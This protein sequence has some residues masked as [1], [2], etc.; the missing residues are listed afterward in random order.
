MLLSRASRAILLISSL[1]YFR[2]RVEKYTS[3]ISSNLVLKRSIWKYLSHPVGRWKGALVVAATRHSGVAASLARGQVAWILR[4]CMKG[5]NF[6]TIYVMR[7]LVGKTLPFSATCDHISLFG[8]GLF[9]TLNSE[10]E[11]I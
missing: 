8:R 9:C 5:C 1:D 7:T 11:Q 2:S 4:Y 10:Q 6:S 3:N